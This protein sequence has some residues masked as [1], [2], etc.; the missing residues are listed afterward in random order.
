M[1]QRLVTTTEMR[2]LE[3]GAVDHGVS[4]EALMDNAGAALAR[5]VRML[6]P[7]GHAL[8]LVGPGNNGGDG[9]VAAQHLHGS[10]WKVSLRL[11]PVKDRNRTRF[12]VL[13]A[14]EPG[15]VPDEPVD[16]V[17]D[18][19]LGTGTSRPIEGPMADLL[20]QVRQRHPRAMVVAADVPSGV[21]ADTGASDPRTLAAHVTVT[22]G[23]AK[24]GLYQYPGA[25]LA[26]E[27]RVA[28]IAIP[29]AVME[30]V[31]TWLSDAELVRPFLPRR[32]QDAHKGTFGK[33]LVVAGA[34]SYTGAPYLTTMAAMRA[35]G[36]LV[37]LATPRSAHAVIAARLVEATFAPLPE[38]DDGWLASGALDRLR[39]LLR[40]EGYDCLLLGPGLG[41]NPQTREAVEALLLG[42]AAELPPRIVIDADGLNILSGI[43]DW[44]RR[45]PPGCVLTPHPA[46]FGR[47]AGLATSD[48]VA[49]RFELARDKAREWGQ[50]ILAKGAN[51]I[52]AAPDGRTAVDPG[53]NPLVATAG[54]GDV[55][56][57]AI[58]GTLTQGANAWEGAVAALRACSLAAA[59]LAPVYGRGGMIASDLH[60]E[61]PRAI[62][63]L[64]GG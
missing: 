22:F 54:T 64:R 6:R 57:G 5:E 25:E 35:G 2:A 32:P 15:P 17:V 36:G 37:R 7:P 30:P 52:V 12:P 33:L 62:K 51:C 60:A 61:I 20:D 4:L 11:T 24:V 16:V 3:Q 39:Q 43:P 27:V 21:N 56:A 1:S 34:A 28:D 44:H 41:H 53:A 63:T 58:A 59:N 42:R 26:G 19:L 10:G 13:R 14:V 9:L 48:V 55:L 49:N 31:R 50:V 47:L 46:E 40:D 8:V 38:T 23:A 45:L 29:A 18:A